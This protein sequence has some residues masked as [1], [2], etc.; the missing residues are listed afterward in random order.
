M[1]KH[2]FIRLALKL[3]GTQKDPI[4]T[5][6]TCNHGFLLGVELLGEHVLVELKKG[7]KII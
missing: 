2:E 7:E 1:C 5:S 3:K 6:A 4:D